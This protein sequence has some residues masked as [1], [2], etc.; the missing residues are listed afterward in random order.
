MCSA[1]TAGASGKLRRVLPEGWLTDE[2]SRPALVDHERRRLVRAASV[3]QAAVAEAE[4]SAVEWRWAHPDVSVE[5]LRVE[6]LW[7]RRTRWLD[8][9]PPAGWNAGHAGADARGR[10][11]LVRDPSAVGASGERVGDGLRVIGYQDGAIETWDVHPTRGLTTVSRWRHD[12]DGRIA[13]GAQ[14]G[15]DG[16][17]RTAR[18]SYDG[19]RVVAI[20][21]LWWFDEAHG[22]KGWGWSRSDVHYDSE[23]RLDQIVR[24]RSVDGATL[25]DYRAR[26]LTPRRLREEL[27]ERLRES[28]LA[29]LTAIDEP[30]AVGAIGLVYDAAGTG[31][32]T[33]VVDR[34]ERFADPARLTFA[35]ASP[36]EW[37]APERDRVDL[38]RYG[39]WPALDEDTGPRTLHRAIR[40][41][42]RDTDRAR[43]QAALRSPTP[44]VLLAMDT[45]REHARQNL[46]DA[47][48]PAAARRM[49]RPGA[50]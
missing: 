20:G 36:L 18:F 1:S 19:N 30:H 40:A 12:G 25:V 21:E 26:P 9:P 37:H 28:V 47:F 39:T 8:K 50:A 22:Q 43:L 17:W 27:G 24:F 4:A 49:L 31:P 10:L 46:S 11:V 6:A 42:V 14:A 15:P 44:P 45:E 29:A 3:W 32:P 34:G 13:E 33:L 23:G 7:G 48:G 41:F 2:P 16:S 35:D 5:P 38:I